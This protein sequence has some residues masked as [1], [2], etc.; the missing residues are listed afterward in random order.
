MN[1]CLWYNSRMNT[2][3]TPEQIELFS[4]WIIENVDEQVVPQDE[5]NGE[6]LVYN[7]VHLLRGTGNK[8][9]YAQDQDA[10]LLTWGL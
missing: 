10:E 1:S 9:R 8:Y 5:G 4:R 7:L 2:S 3:L 6:A